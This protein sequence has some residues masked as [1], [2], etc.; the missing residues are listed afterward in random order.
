MNDALMADWAFLDEDPANTATG[1]TLV[2]LQS[3]IRIS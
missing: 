3:K 2:T 1:P